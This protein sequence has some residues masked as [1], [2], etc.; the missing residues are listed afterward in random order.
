MEDI[1]MAN[2]IN[3]FMPYN[4]GA[5][6]RQVDRTVKQTFPTT[7]PRTVPR[8]F[9]SNRPPSVLGTT[10]VSA[11]RA[12]EALTITESR[13]LRNDAYVKNF[14]QG[15]MSGGRG[16]TGERRKRKM[17]ILRDILE[18]QVRIR[19]AGGIDEVKKI[20]SRLRQGGALSEA[21]VRRI[22]KAGY[23]VA[24]ILKTI[25]DK[26]KRDFP[27]VHA[28]RQ[29]QDFKEA[30]TRN[31]DITFE[32]SLEDTEEKVLAKAGVDMETYESFIEGIRIGSSSER[33]ELLEEFETY[34]DDAYRVLANRLINERI[35]EAMDIPRLTPAEVKASE[36]IDA[37]LNVFRREGL[38]ASAD[39]P[40]TPFEADQDYRRAMEDVSEEATVEEEVRD[41]FQDDAAMGITLNLAME[42]IQNEVIQDL[43][44]EFISQIPP[45]ADMAGE[46]EGKSEEIPP[47][48]ALVRQPTPPSSSPEEPRS[49]QSSLARLG[50][51]Q[52]RASLRPGG[53]GG[54]GEWPRG[55]LVEVQPRAR[56]SEEELERSREADRARGEEL[57]RQAQA[58]REGREE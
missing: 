2:R 14:G 5:Q 31:K 23:D 42:E 17:K 50:G 15:V 48:P 18:E 10:I 26:V 16:M 52:R 44:R 38:T 6:M 3:D 22:E 21:E 53:G 51:G 56:L 37:V 34:G 35:M 49:R 40:S 25:D 12:K 30:K 29:F 55:R 13:R 4:Y 9:V 7:L 8:G 41:P 32:Q 54:G 46:P 47:P 58:R 39:D 36:R 57:A 33:E 1:R 43:A 28:S 24:E 19:E 11:N 20:V 27:E 45:G